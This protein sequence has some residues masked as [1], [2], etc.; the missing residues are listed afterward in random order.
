MGSERAEHF[1][2]ASG[3]YELGDSDMPRNHHDELSKLD[4][5]EALLSTARDLALR[6]HGQ[7]MKHVGRLLQDVLQEVG[8]AR[9]TKISNWQNAASSR[10]GPPR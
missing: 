9:D 1:Y 6:F 2:K 7:E 8:H 10:V 3:F 4:D 5:I